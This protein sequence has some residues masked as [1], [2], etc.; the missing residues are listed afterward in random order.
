MK[1]IGISVEKIENLG[2]SE[3]KQ[4]KSGVWKTYSYWRIRNVFIVW[5]HSFYSEYFFL[6]DKQTR[7][8]KNLE[9]FYHQSSTIRHPPSVSP[10]VSKIMRRYSEKRT[11]CATDSLIPRY[12]H[13]NNRLFFYHNGKPGPILL[14]FCFYISIPK[15]ELFTTFKKYHIYLQIK[16]VSFRKKYSLF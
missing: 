14:D 15:M 3:Q 4:A 7:V 12:P 16:A 1:Q 5:I 9:C 13:L 2:I 11:G 10:V 8:S 6:N